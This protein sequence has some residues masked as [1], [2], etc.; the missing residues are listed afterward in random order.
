MPT[1]PR[2]AL[3]AGRLSPGY[4]RGALTRIHKEF[5]HEQA[6]QEFVVSAQD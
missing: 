4:N 6:A 5:Y 3:I 2:K 1:D